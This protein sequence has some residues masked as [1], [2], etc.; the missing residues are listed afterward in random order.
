[1]IPGW[2]ARMRPPADVD[3]GA[4]VAAD[5]D[6]DLAVG[7]TLDVSPPAAASLDARYAGVCTFLVVCDNALFVRMR[8]SGS[9]TDG[10]EG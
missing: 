6:A 3:A 8:S 2:R 4:D 7:F 10:V 1:M 5:I 9:S